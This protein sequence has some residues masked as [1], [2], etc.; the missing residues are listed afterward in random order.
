[1]R[2][3]RLNCPLRDYPT[4]SPQSSQRSQRPIRFQ[5]PGPGARAKVFRTAPHVFSRRAFGHGKF[6]CAL[7]RQR[8]ICG[9]NA[10]SGIMVVLIAPGPNSVLTGPAAAGMVP[11]AA[12]GSAPGP[13]FTPSAWDRAS[14]APLEFPRRA[15]REGDGVSPDRRVPARAGRGDLN[16]D[17]PVQSQR[18]QRAQR[19]SPY[20]KR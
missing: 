15:I 2:P 17:R 1:M 13:F 20:S 16:P 14:R 12:V 8:R 10:F 6:P 9:S 5:A 7:V 18:A 19:K 11:F 3:L 4:Y